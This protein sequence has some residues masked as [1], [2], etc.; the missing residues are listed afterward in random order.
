MDKDVVTSTTLTLESANK[1]ALEQNPNFMKAMQTYNA[2]I[3][4]A[5]DYIH[6]NS[7]V[8]QLSISRYFYPGNDSVWNAKDTTT[9]Y[10]SGIRLNTTRTN[11]YEHIY[12]FT[13]TKELHYILI[14]EGWSQI[15]SFPNP[16]FELYIKRNG[17]RFVY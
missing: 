2:I 10:L 11:K 15:G 6:N 1:N 8:S 9:Y 13:M 3:K 16:T 7:P 17:I 4:Y 5:V 12:N 14:T